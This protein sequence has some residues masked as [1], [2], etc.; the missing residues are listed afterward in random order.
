MKI[1]CKILSLSLLFLIY[2][3][4]YFFYT[5]KASFILYNK[6]SLLAT[7]NKKKNVINLPF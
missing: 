6:S 1:V 4:K 3:L 7:S 5:V 2:Y